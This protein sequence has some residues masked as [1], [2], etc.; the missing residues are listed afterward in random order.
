MEPYDILCPPAPVAW[1]FLVGV[2]RSVFAISLLVTKHFYL[3]SSGRDSPFSCFS[4]QVSGRGWCRLEKETDM[5][6]LQARVWCCLGYSVPGGPHK[7]ASALADTLHPQGTTLPC[8]SCTPCV[9]LSERSPGQG[10]I[11]MG[12][13]FPIWKP[14]V[15]AADPWG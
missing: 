12:R 1:S 9:R 13:A 14:P 7:A 6:L 3:F 15:S 4:S 2:H 8:S 10:E 5:S 11:T